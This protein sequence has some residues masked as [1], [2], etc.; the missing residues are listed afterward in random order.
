MLFRS[1]CGTE[2]PEAWRR[3]VVALGADGDLAFDGDGDRVLL[4]DAAGEV[5]DGDP[6]LHLLARD[7]K[8]R[9]RLA[10]NRVVATVMSNLGLERTLAAA[11]IALDRVPVG[12]RHVA[13]RMRET[14]AALGGEQSG[15]V[16]LAFDGVLVGDGL[17]AGVK[18]LQAA[19]RRGSTLADARR[20]VPRFPQ[21]LRNVRVARKI[22]LDHA[23][24]FA[25][26]IRAEEAGLK[27]EGRVLVRYSGTE[28]LLRIM[29]EGS[30]AAQVKGVVDR[31]EI[32][33]HQMA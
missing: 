19:R 29:V 3:A 8:A 17:V 4:A 11:R 10:G 5:L 2:H 23:P 25:A 22:P 24:S 26:K 30:D 31:L 18:A 28:P 14:G 32:A 9:R 13:A 12:D 33:A 15:H 6:V 1:R 27:G 16:L 20:E 7:M 21:V